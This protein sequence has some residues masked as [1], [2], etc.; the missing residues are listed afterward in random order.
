MFTSLRECK[1]SIRWCQFLHPSADQRRAAKGV[2]QLGK[3]IVKKE[4][5]TI[6]F[7]SSGSD[8]NRAEEGAILGT[9]DYHCCCSVT[10]SCPTLCNPMNCSKPGISDLHYLLDFSQI[11]VH[12]VGDAIQP[13]HPLPP[14]YLLAFNLSQHQGLFH[15]VDSLHQVAKVLELQ[16]QHQSFQWIFVVDFL[17]DW[18]L[19]SPCSPRDSQESSLAWQ[20]ESI[21]SL[22]LSLLYGLTSLHDYWKNDSFNYMDLCWQSDISAF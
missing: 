5:S 16:L 11:R 12:W 7:F 22:V 13:S 18:L 17:L 2:A 3:Q 14:P 20:F 8:L 4:E 19:W 9:T 15:W 6:P 1:I 10:K 21:N